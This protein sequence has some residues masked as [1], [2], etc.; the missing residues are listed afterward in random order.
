MVTLTNQ[1]RAAS[2]LPALTVDATLRSVARSRSKDMAERDYF[3]HRIPPDGHTAF[4]E[5]KARGYC[6][7][8]AAENFARNNYPDSEAT[9]AAQRGF[10]GS[11]VHLAA[12]LG[13]R[14]TRIGVGAYKGA[15]G[16]HVWTV[17]FAQPC[18]ST[19]T[20]SPR[21]AATPRPTAAVRVRVAQPAAP[22]AAPVPE[23]PEPPGPEVAGP[24]ESP[25]SAVEGLAWPPDDTDA[26]APATVPAL[27]ALLESVL[28]IIQFLLSLLGPAP[29]ASTSP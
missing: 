18:G 17:L 12:I 26:A 15:D 1:R 29:P 23:L 25:A 10:E 9:R 20:A 3:S 13:S 4:D 6:L 2:G 28:A 27:Q 5:L 19:A 14:Y 21:R 7:R 16:M 11:S 22:T 8:T 24:L